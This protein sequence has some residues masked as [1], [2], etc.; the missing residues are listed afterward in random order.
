MPRTAYR[1]NVPPAR[2]SRF[3]LIAALLLVYWGTGAIA[4][5]G[6]GTRINSRSLLSSHDVHPH[7][8]S[9]FKPTRRRS[10]AG[11]LYPYPL[12][13]NA[14]SESD[15]EL[16][17]RGSVELGY[18][19]DID[20]TN[21]AYWENYVDR[22]SGILLNQFS[23]DLQHRDNAGYAHVDGGSIG[24][25]DQFVRVEAGVFGWLRVKGMY[26][27]VP[28]RL[29]NDAKTIFQGVGTEALRLPVGLTPGA[30]TESEID[31]ILGDLPFHSLAVDRERGRIGVEAKPLRNLRLFAEYRHEERQGERPIGASTGFAFAGVLGGNVIELIEPIDY[32][33]HDYAVGVQVLHRR[34]QL[35]VSYHASYFDNDNDNDNE[36]LS[37]ENPFALS[38][39][40]AG[41]SALAPDNHCHNL[42][43]DLGLTLPLTGR[44]T[45]SLSWSRAKQ[46][47]RLLSP[48]VNP[49]APD[50]LDPA[51]ALAQR[52]ANAE[53][54]TLLSH[55]RLQFRPL[56]QIQLKGELRY[57]KRDS[58]TSYVAYNPAIDFYGYIPEDA[59]FG[60]NSTIP[61]YQSVPYGYD[62]WNGKAGAVIRALYRTTVELEYE[63]ETVNRDHRVREHTKEDRYRISATTRSLRFATLRFS[64]EHGDKR[65]DDVDVSRDF[66]F[67]SAGPPDFAF[68]EPF[69]SSTPLRSVAQ[70]RQYDLANRKQNVVKARANA[71]LGDWADVSVSLRYFDNDYDALYGINYDRRGDANF[72]VA[73]LPSRSSVHQYSRASNGAVDKCVRSTVNVFARRLAKT[74]STLL[75]RPYSQ[76]VFPDWEPA[77]PTP[78]TDSRTNG[79]WIAR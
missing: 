32:E 14:F 11:F 47:E 28:H 21:E 24:R 62:R 53:F 54:T 9:F 31:T 76:W 68:P 7:G 58:D 37:W 40:V 22:S 78:Y 64:Y 23:V 66:A 72:E 46:D 43:G 30:S 35:N 29:M 10:P 27:E 8:M 26:D 3:E 17:T 79:R 33:T 69:T 59:F 6:A 52:N 4:D 73:F 63:R 50:W 16:L 25:D 34:L 12:K 65:G 67:Y 61:R 15:Q 49:L 19:T 51:T 44:F 39:S 74:P 41:Q 5:E 36:S 13:P 70:L 45:T 57:F 1:S 60:S 71:A 38:S 20:D 56:R 77:R 2:F 48:T 75:T 42:K 18:V 55:S